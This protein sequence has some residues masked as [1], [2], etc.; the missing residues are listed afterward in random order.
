MVFRVFFRFKMSDGGGAT[1]D[2]VGGVIFDFIDSDASGATSG[3]CKCK[4]PYVILT[5]EKGIKAHYTECED[6][7]FRWEMTTTGVMDS[8]FVRKLFHS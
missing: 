7:P 5:N 2:N 4:E 3:G 8:R 6:E 1:E